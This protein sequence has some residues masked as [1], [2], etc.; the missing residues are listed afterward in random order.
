MGEFMTMEEAATQLEVPEAT[1]RQWIQRGRA[2]ASR[3]GGTYVLRLREVERLAQAELGVT[4]QLQS[5]ETPERLLSPINLS[6]GLSA[7]REGEGEGKPRRALPPRPRDAGPEEDGA[8]IDR[9]KRLGRRK[10]DFSLEILANEV[11]QAVAQ[12]LELQREIVGEALAPVL[13]KLDRLQAPSSAAPLLSILPRREEPD[14]AVL[15]ELEELR[16]AVAARERQLRHSQQENVQ[17]RQRSLELEGLR[18]L[19][20][21]NQ[22]LTA[23]LA[24]A[25]AHGA[26]LAL[27]TGELRSEIRGLKARLNDASRQ[28]AQSDPASEER[29]RAAEAALRQAQLEQRE[30]LGQVAEL[31]GELELTQ[32]AHMETLASSQGA[33]G[34]L[35][36]LERELMRERSQVSRLAAELEDLRRAAAD[37]VGR[38]NEN[39]RLRADLHQLQE[40]NLRFEA[41]RARLATEF[42]TLRNEAESAWESSRRSEEQRRHVHEQYT[43]ASQQL[44]RIQT[45]LSLLERESEQSQRRSDEREQQLSAENRRLKEQLTELQYRSQMADSGQSMANLEDSRRMMDQLVDLQNQMEEKD[46]Q[47]AQDYSDRAELRAK[48][49]EVNRAYYELQHRY[50]KEK[51]EWSQVVARQIQ[52]ASERERAA[53]QPPPNT[54]GP[55]K[56]TSW[57]KGLFKLKGDA[58]R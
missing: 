26:E 32:R 45:R 8:P 22:E 51:E 30:A 6:L 49:E 57:G 56:D 41:E 4:L 36:E 37:A 12:G 53:S 35:L 21:R 2:R 52:S 44:E 39:E 42:S 20:L 50:D 40:M 23:Q 9:R 55:K 5:A 48:L 43:V 17:L 14:P 54:A 18:D 31:R 19:A 1:L 33:S 3:R 15:E 46:R 16:Q 58:D 29:L 38:Q 11:R 27:E 47:I 7:E 34:Q 28:A 10:S 24:A 13:Q 25:Q